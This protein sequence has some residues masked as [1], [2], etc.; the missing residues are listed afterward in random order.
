MFAL[1]IIGILM[2]VGFVIGVFNLLR[3]E[4]KDFLDRVAF[5]RRNRLLPGTPPGLTPQL[6]TYS[7]L[8]RKI[9]TENI[10]DIFARL[11]HPN[12]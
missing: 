7:K 12:S 1:R 4:W 5:A 8:R 10:S 2:V 9:P 6:C 3:Q 11:S